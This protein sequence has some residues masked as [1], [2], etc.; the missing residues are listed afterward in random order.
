M[1]KTSMLL[2]RIDDHSLLHLK[3]EIEC[4]E[5]QKRRPLAGLMMKPAEDVVMILKNLAC[6]LST[7]PQ[8]QLATSHGFLELLA[9]ALNHKF[10]EVRDCAFLV[11]TQCL[12]ES[13]TGNLGQDALPFVNHLLKL[14]QD[15][16]ENRKLS[17]SQYAIFF[18]T[19]SLLCGT[20]KRLRDEFLH[21]VPLTVLLKTNVT[22]L[23]LGA[24][25]QLSKALHALLL[26]GTPDANLAFDLLE[27]VNKIVEISEP[28]CS[29]SAAACATLSKI[30]NALR[31]EQA[32][33][34]QKSSATIR[35][36]SER[37]ASAECCDRCTSTYFELMEEV[38]R[39]EDADLFFIS[40]YG[41]Q[42]LRVVLHERGGE[43]VG[44]VC[45]I[46][47]KLL[48]GAPH[49]I[50]LIVHYDLISPI[51]ILASDPDARTRKDAQGT[52]NNFMTRANFG[53]WYQAIQLGFVESLM[54]P[55]LSE[56]STIVLEAVQIC[57]SFMLSAQ[58]A[59]IESYVLQK[60]L[61][62]ELHEIFAD[63]LS[64][65]NEMVAS[66]CREFFDRYFREE[67]AE[68]EFEQETSF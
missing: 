26:H 9:A 16:F 29:V 64:Y 30:L 35:Q 60:M 46:L 7:P 39:T 3:N 59:E 5:S 33:F 40:N 27:M 44:P 14:T 47:A 6:H 20:N 25:T 65:D 61:S 18:K 28:S 37:V 41:L 38:L 63:L 55:L 15:F 17:S 31:M 34:L 32:S 45:R 11:A 52:L 10:V 8:W 58:N 56:D 54:I 13:A 67:Y 43:P 36:L 21:V 1:F 42:V 12:S 4:M 66:A 68:G 53:H 23:S 50:S 62:N 57:F 51:V 49:Q 24:L 48:T 19:M 22:R 2:G